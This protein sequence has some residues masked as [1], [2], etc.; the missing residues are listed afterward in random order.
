MT[1]DKEYLVEV[2]L[3]SHN[4]QLKCPLH[5]AHWTLNTAHFTLHTT[6]YTLHTAQCKCPAWLNIVGSFFQRPQK[7][8][9]SALAWEG[10]LYWQL[11]NLN[12]TINC[13]LSTLLYTVYC[14]LLSILCTVNCTLYCVLST[15]LHIVYCQMYYILCTVNSIVYCVR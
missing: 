2:N 3:P 13:V 15:V 6:H 12:C 5:T 9:P 10:T 4:A 7:E 14:Q 8:W 11:C 1:K